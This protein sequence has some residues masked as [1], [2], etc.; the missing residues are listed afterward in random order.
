MNLKQ[1]L[2]MTFIGLSLM[3]NAW[4]HTSSVQEFVCP[5]GGEKFRQRIDMSGTSFGIMTD[6]RPVG[7]IAT[8]FAIPQCPSN[9]FVIFKKE[10][11]PSELAKFER[12]VQSDAY[13]K[14]AQQSSSY[15]A[16]GHM[17]ELAEENQDNIQMMWIFLKS[18][19]QRHNNEA[20][21]KTLEYADKALAHSSFQND[22]EKVTV[23]LLRGEMLRKLKRFDEAKTWFQTLQNSP[24]VTDKPYLT[25]L[26]AFQLKLVEQQD[27]QSHHIDF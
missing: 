24:L 18:S 22:D 14:I 25:Q 23:Q 1:K 7:P 13:Q 2:M 9:R 15:F 10:F 4:A 5:I 21:Q 17:L 3:H 8:P 11:T 12:V 19:W 16:W 26:L 27:H 20:L 6:T